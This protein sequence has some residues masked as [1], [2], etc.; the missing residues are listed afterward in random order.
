MTTLMHFAVWTAL[1]LGIPICDIDPTISQCGDRQQISG[2]K[3]ANTY[4]SD[5]RDLRKVW[6]IYNGF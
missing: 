3:S 4:S 5:S 6:K 2:E 1:Q